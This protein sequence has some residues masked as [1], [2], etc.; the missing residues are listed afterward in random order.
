MVTETLR[1]ELGLRDLVLFNVAAVVGIRWLAAAAHTGPVSIWLW[2]SAA[3][4]FFVPTALVVGRLAQ[5]MPEEGGIYVWTRAEFGEW[6]GFL[7]GWCYWL[8][9]FF[10]FP[11]L[12]LAGVTMAAYIAGPEWIA[13]AESPRFAIPAATAVIVAVTAL[14]LP[15]LASGKWVGN[16]GGAATYAAGLMIVAGGIAAAWLRGPATAMT[17]PEIG[18]DKVN[19]WPQIAFAFGGLELGA[20]LG[21][22][23]RDAARTVRRAAWISGGAITG[24]YI[25]GTLAILA[26]LEPGQ[27]SVVTGLAQAGHAAGEALSMGAAGPILAGLVTLGIAGQ[28]GAWMTGTARLPV[29]FG[30]DR[31][32]P[33]SF[34][35]TRR[36]L[37]GQSAACIAL[38]FAAQAGDNFRTGYQLLVDMTVITYFIP[39]LYLFLAGWRRG[40]RPSTVAGLT[41]TSIAIAF[42]FI[43][44]GGA[45][46]AWLFAAK[47]LAG[48]AAVVAAARLLYLK[49]RMA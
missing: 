41:V 37:A 27:I 15:G 8:N 30:I 31:L 17:I 40:A 47:L 5:A 36:V 3:L 14:S 19:F 26:L 42:S 18:W 48:V 25:A 24:F 38:L 34:A 7:C 45:E 16:I 9:N 23:I 21:G 13:E 12:V 2:A 46:S 11:S 35:D 28:L 43:P 39:F 29:V 32:L 1:R 10:Y 22:E 49:R 44:P 33:A 4:C 6:H 20:I